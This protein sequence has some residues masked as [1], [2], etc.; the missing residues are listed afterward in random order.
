MTTS[1]WPVVVRRFP[2][3]TVSTPR[4]VIRPLTAD[5]AAP[6]AEIF[7][8]RQ[9]GRWLA[10]PQRYGPSDGFA[11][12]ADLAEERRDRGEGDHYGV[13]RRVDD[14]LIGCAWTRRADWIARSIE[15]S[16][17]IAPD[18]RGYAIASETVDALAVALVLEHGFQRIE[19]R[20]A[21]GN[22]AA[23]RVAEKAGFCYEGLLRNAGQLA[24]GRVDL[25]MWSLVAAD[26]R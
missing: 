3:L 10:V 21:A 26:L 11:W 2:T 15:V 4:L 16:F 9:T 22:V 24:S 17:A 8:D 14:R 13:V 1:S 18:A 20:V 12:C 25:E 19:L 23:R 7:S 5:D 6:V